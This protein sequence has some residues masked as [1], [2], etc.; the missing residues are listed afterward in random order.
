VV[1][2]IPI[3]P[4]RKEGEKLPGLGGLLLKRPIIIKSKL[5]TLRCAQGDII[6]YLKK[7][8]F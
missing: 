4:E 1:E 5:E 8:S 6:N 3:S 7:Q 2:S